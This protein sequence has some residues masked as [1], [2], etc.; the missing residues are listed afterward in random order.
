MLGDDWTALDFANCH[1]NIMH[2]ALAASGKAGFSKLA[3]YC[4]DR[5]RVLQEVMDTYGVDRDAAKRLFIRLLYLGS[6]EAWAK[7]H[8]LGDVSVM[9]FIAQ[10]AR[11]ME[12]AANLIVE[13]N[14]TMREALKPNER[15]KAKQEKRGPGRP[16]KKPKL[17]QA[18]GETE[19]PLKASRDQVVS[20]FCQEYERRLLRHF[21]DFC[22]ERGLLTVE[23]GKPVNCML[24]YDGIDVRKTDWA[25]AVADPQTFFEDAQRYIADK[26]GFQ[27]TITEKPYAPSPLAAQI[28]AEADLDKRIPENAC[29]ELMPRA[30]IDLQE[31]DAQK[32]YFERFVVKI[33]NAA[34]FGWKMWDHGDNMVDAKLR[35]EGELKTSF[36]HIKTKFVSD[37]GEVKQG[38]FIE[39]WLRDEEMRT[40]NHIDFVPYS[41]PAQGEILSSGSLFNLFSGYPI[42]RNVT[43]DR[44]ASSYLEQ[45]H[46]IGLQLCE[47]DPL[48]YQCMWLYLAQLVQHPDQRPDVSFC[49]QDKPSGAGADLYFDTIGEIIGRKYYTNSSNVDDMFGNH[50]EGTVNKLLGLQRVGVQAYGRESST[51]QGFDHIDAPVSEPEAPATIHCAQLSP[52]LLLLEQA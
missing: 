21:F 38:L 3:E 30:L 5:D 23:P 44:P 41:D 31:Y 24:R 7:D 43:L 29:D 52:D 40:S 49:F 37:D 45:F 33:I 39:R 12:S 48:K 42:P 35:N 4:A 6:F 16:P 11:E 28:E 26:T 18:S 27:I 51:D 10:F 25:R 8:A 34:S 1:P 46:F 17:E 14:P 15:A 22:V 13:A 47:N 2:Q 36:K 9:P 50:A 32:A 20:M 19:E